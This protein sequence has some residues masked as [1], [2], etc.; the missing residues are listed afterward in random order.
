RSPVLSGHQHCPYFDDDH[1]LVRYFPAVVAPILG[2]DSRLQSAARI[3][4]AEIDPRK[5]IMPPVTTINGAAVRLFEPGEEL[6]VG[7]GIETCLAAYELFGV[8]TWAALSAHGLESFE[9]PAGLMRLHIY[10]DNDLNYVGQAA[11]FALAKRL[12]RTGQIVEVHVPPD[13][14]DWLDV[15]NNRRRR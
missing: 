2:P 10:A 15:L 6:G 5:K 3:Y 7:E 8:P 14:G 13:P 12:C 9:P 1:R 4:D 11:A